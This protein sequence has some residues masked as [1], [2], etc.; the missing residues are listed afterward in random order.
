MRSS[1][2]CK[3][4]SNSAMGGSGLKEA[5]PDQLKNMNVL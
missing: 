1:I 2:G 4:I 5:T 3:S